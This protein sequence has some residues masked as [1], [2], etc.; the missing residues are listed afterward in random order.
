MLFIVKIF[1]RIM[2]PKENS[3]NQICFFLSL[4][5]CMVICNNYYSIKGASDLKACLDYSYNH[6][7]LNFEFFCPNSLVIRTEKP[8]CDVEP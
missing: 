7:I 2:K 5:F 3:V 1:T 8:E 6:A 4:S